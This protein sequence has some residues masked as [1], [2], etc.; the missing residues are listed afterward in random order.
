M[1]DTDKKKGGFE[2]VSRRNYVE[3]SDDEDEQKSNHIVQ[4]GN[5]GMES[6]THMVVVL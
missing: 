6:G 3:I 2:N 4:N 5:V 1:N